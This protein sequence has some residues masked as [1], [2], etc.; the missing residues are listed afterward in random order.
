[1]RSTNGLTYFDGRDV[2]AI[3][4]LRAKTIT[5][6]STVVTQISLDNSGARVT[7]M[8]DAN[9]VNAIAT[10]SPPTDVVINHRSL[11]TGK[12]PLQGRESSST[13]VTFMLRQMGS[14]GTISDTQ[15]ELNDTDTT[16]FGIEV[17]TTHS[18]GKFSLQNIPSGRFILT[19]SVPRH[20]TGH[21][22]IDVK[23]GFE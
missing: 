15:F 1:M 20:L 13:E 23:P 14:Y 17:Q 19:A 22:T 21:D 2:L 12:V 9:N 18:D 7:K 11:V 6:S 16:K 8:L 5:G 3:A 10:V 4:N